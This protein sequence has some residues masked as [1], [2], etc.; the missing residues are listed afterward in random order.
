MSFESQKQ[1]WS[2]IPID[3]SGYFAISELMAKS[4]RELKEI[5]ERFE[6]TRYNPKEWRNHDNKWRSTLGLD[7]T[8]GKRILDYGC[9]LGIEA[10]QFAKAGNRVSIADLSLDGLYLAQ[11]VLNLYG[12]EPE[13][14]AVIS[15]KYPFIHMPSDWKFDIFYSNGVIHHIPNAPEV[16]SHAF[17][18]LNDDGE[19]RLMLYS[20]KGRDIAQKRGEDFVRFFDDVGEYADWYDRKKIEQSFGDKIVQFDYITPDERYL[21]VT[22]KK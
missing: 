17:E 12:F 6:A 20:D 8:K 16:I 4:D 11:R 2:K 18:I 15:E 1:A 9:G 19:I 7:T 3:D 10:L 21:T 5:V 22:L 14:C 13:L